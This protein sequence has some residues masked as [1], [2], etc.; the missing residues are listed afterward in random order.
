MADWGRVG[1]EAAAGGCRLV[2][3]PGNR[4]EGPEVVDPDA[5]LGSDWLWGKRAALEGV[6]LRMLT[7]AVWE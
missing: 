5:M 4:E 7:K 6:R 2:S 3:S 1:S